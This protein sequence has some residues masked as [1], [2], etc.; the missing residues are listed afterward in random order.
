MTKTEQHEL[1]ILRVLVQ[2]DENGRGGMTADEIKNLFHELIGKDREG[3]EFFRH[4][5]K[6]YMV[7]RMK[8][9]QTFF[10][11]TVL[12]KFRLRDLEM[13]DMEELKNNTAKRK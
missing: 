13:L 11:P 3:E 6:H 8:E 7:F 1:A 12:G 5:M 4:M 2:N 10:F 9:S